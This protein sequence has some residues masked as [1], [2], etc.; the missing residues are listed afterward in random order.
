M[1]L[2]Q[3]VNPFRGDLAVA[4]STLAAAAL[5]NPLRR[6]VQEIVNR[7]FNRTRYDNQRMIEAFG[8]HLQTEAD[9]SKIETELIGI[10]AS[11]VAPTQLAVWIRSTP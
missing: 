7:L 4:G 6:R 10:T 9:L 11:T 3:L 1:L 5:F 2:L 8:Q